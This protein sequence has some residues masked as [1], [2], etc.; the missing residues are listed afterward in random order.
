M[1][2]VEAR[3]GRPVEDVISEVY[4]RGGMQRDVAEVLGVEVSTVSRWMKELGIVARPTG[5]GSK[6]A[7]AE[8]TA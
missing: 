8:P 2:L 5:A 4:G 7:L 1:Q 3:L 6:A